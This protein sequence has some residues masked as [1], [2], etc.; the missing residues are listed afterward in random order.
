MDRTFRGG[1]TSATDFELSVLTNRHP[2]Y[3]P[4]K[5][6]FMDEWIK[7]TENGISVLRIFKIKV[8]YAVVLCST[9]RPSFA[10]MLRFRRPMSWL[11][12]RPNPAA[13]SNWAWLLLMFSHYLIVT[14]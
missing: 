5:E 12:E 6:Q 13:R 9:G 10:R 3:R 1:T 4:R 2:E 14:I 7:S 11:T 8:C